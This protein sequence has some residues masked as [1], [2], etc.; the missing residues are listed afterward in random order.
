MGKTAFFLLENNPRKDTVALFESSISELSTCVDAEKMPCVTQSL[1]FVSVASIQ[2]DYLT[3]RNKQINKFQKLN[4]NTK[5][6]GVIVWQIKS[7]RVR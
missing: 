1:V 4:G 6:H 2:C 5:A 7:R 3:D